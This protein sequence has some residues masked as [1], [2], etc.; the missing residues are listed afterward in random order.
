MET[1]HPTNLYRNTDMVTMPEPETWAP[2]D[3]QPF[4]GRCI[5]S[6]WAQKQLHYTLKTWASSDIAQPLGAIAHP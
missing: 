4:W 3:L 1:W 5:S 2:V 6:I